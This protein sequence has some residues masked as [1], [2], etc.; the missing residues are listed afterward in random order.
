VKWYDAPTSHASSPARSKSFCMSD[1][2][3]GRD[4]KGLR[5]SAPSPVVEAAR[6]STK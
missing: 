1:K 5:M 4:P 6:L 2:K 3:L